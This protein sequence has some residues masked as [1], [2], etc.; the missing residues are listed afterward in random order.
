MHGK[1][2]FILFCAALIIIFG[3]SSV[4]ADSLKFNFKEFGLFGSFLKSKLKEQGDYEVLPIIYRFG[5]DLRP[6]LKDKSR[7]LI[8]L[9]IEPF[10]GPVISPNNN[11]ELGCNLLLKFAPNIKERF[12][13]YIE[14]GVGAVYLTQHTREQGSQFNFSETVGI[15]ITCLVKKNLALNVGYRYR[16]ISNA[17]IKRPNSGIDARSVIAGISL[18][19]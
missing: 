10:T 4:T 7:N 14:G 15:G 19:Y 3:V 2:T 11:A 12:F 8:E 6:F 9:L 18:F 13:P 16:H 17:S 5:F 1:R